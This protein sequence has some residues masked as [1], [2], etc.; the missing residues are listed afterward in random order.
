METEY[1]YMYQIAH[2]FIH[3]KS[4]QGVVSALKSGPSEYTNYF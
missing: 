4:S 2:N 3:H 1:I